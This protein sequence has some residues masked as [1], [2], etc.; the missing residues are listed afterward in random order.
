VLLP[1]VVLVV[2]VDLPLLRRIYV[3]PYEGITMIF[4]AFQAE[5]DL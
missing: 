4:G 1:S 5:T 2:S 3:G